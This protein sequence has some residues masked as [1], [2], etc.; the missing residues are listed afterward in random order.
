MP[1]TGGITWLNFADT[2][3]C[4]GDPGALIRKPDAMLNAFYISKIQRV[5]PFTKKMEDLGGFVM[6]DSGGFQA[7][8]LNQHVN[9]KQIVLN[10]QQLCS[11][12]IILDKPPYEI[13]EGSISESFLPEHFENCLSKTVRNVQMMTEGITRSD[14]VL[15]GVVHGADPQTSIRWYETVKKVLP[16]KYWCMTPKPA[17]PESITRF[18]LLAH[19]LGIKNLHILGV[20]SARTMLLLEYLK[21][22]FDDDFEVVT[23]D[24]STMYRDAS[25]R[26]LYEVAKDP[27][28]GDAT[29]EGYYVGTRSKKMG[30]TKDSVVCD[31]EVCKVTDPALF[32]HPKTGW[33]VAELAFSHNWATWM[34]Y[35]DE[36]LKDVDGYFTRTMRESNGVKKVIA[37]YKARPESIL[38]YQH[39]QQ[40]ELF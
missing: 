6:A 16:T 26:I 7:F 23:Y 40:E 39:I 27:D 34:R 21:T 20:G 36:V 25:M 24:S 30:K 1:C 38:E 31:C 9:P 3:K 29:F 19:Y 2:G 11:H 10:Q 8:S 33:K 22:E 17:T 14:F 4:W 15:Y 35:R 28:T 32:R 37:S 5:A 18:F 12:G 13:R